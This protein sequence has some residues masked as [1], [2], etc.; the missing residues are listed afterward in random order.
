MVR[1]AATKRA[2]GGCLI[3]Q[4]KPVEGSSNWPFILGEG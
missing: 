2:G 3:G 4:R 1:H